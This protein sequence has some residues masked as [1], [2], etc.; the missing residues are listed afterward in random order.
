[1]VPV[2]ALVAVGRD[3]HGMTGGVSLDLRALL[4]G[5]EWSLAERGRQ[6][7]P[8]RHQS[9]MAGRR[10]VAY[11]HGGVTDRSPATGAAGD[12]PLGHPTPQRLPAV[13]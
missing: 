7:G 8:E 5:G 9:M 6:V 4:E 1:M 11:P 3:A 13:A 2:D 10:S 12:A